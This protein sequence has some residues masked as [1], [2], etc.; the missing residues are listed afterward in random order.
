MCME[1][2]FFGRPIVSQGGN[3]IH[4]R[5]VVALA[6][7]CIS[8]PAI[9][10]AGER[11][12]GTLHEASVLVATREADV[13]EHPQPISSHRDDD[14][15]L[16]PISQIAEHTPELADQTSA[17][18]TSAQD[19]A[20]KDDKF[21]GALA[22]ATQPR[23]LSA[24]PAKFNGIQ[25]GKSTKDDVLAGWK[26]PDKTKST[27]DGSVLI[28]KTKPFR[29]VEVQLTGKL[30]TAIKIELQGTLSPKRLARQ[31][32]LD[33]FDPV[34]V[35]DDQGAM[36]GQIYPKR[37]VL[38]LFAPSSDV[39]AATTTPR[40][41]AVT[42]VVIQPLDADA[43]ALRA[44]TR[45]HGPYERNIEDL[46]TALALNPDLA[47]AQWLL[48]EIY[49]ATG[50]ADLAMEAADEACAIDPK[51]AAY[52]LRRAQ[53]QS[54]LGRYDDATLGVRDVLDRESTPPIVKA[55]A[56]HE[57]AILAT[58]GDAEI[59]SKA[60]PFDNRAIA[61][62]DSLATSKNIKERRAAKELLIEAHLAIAKQVAGNPFSNKLESVSQWVGRASGLAED[63]I[64]HDDGSVELRL[65]VAREALAALASLKPTKDPGPWIK[66]AEQ[67]ST[68]L[69]QQCDDELWRRRIQWELGQAYFQAVG[70]EHLRLQ[71]ESALRYGQLA[72]EN[73]AEG[74]ANRQSTYES[75]Q[76]VGKLY[77]HIGVVHAV[78]KKDHKTAA[79]W[80]DKALPL[81]TT[82]RPTSD[83]LAPQHDGE[84]LVSMAV[85]YWQIGEKDHAID[86]TLNGIELAEEAVVDGLLPE[87]SLAVPYGNLSAMYQQLGS[88]EDAAKYASLA[89]N[90]GGTPSPTAA[91][92]KRS[93]TTRRTPT[94]TAGQKRMLPPTVAQ[95]PSTSRWTPSPA[96][97]TAMRPS[98]TN[99][100]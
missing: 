84:E 77:F 46:E 81:L 66:E 11:G 63:M 21:G 92:N 33:K 54:A 13:D 12:A 38:F 85:S 94:M 59:S 39:I 87:K 68:A 15:T 1:V 7:L 6:G 73:L 55:Q 93:S 75:E 18:V 42:H 72:I 45:L 61:L 70:I 20:E 69:T 64:A 9:G 41:A 74:A 16:E 30:V 17:E 34:A 24:Q 51:N 99:M 86:L 8:T 47:H 97:R 56:L 88:A 43:F 35:T 60:I 49:L 28:Y 26:E 14:G 65:L 80:Y 23:K 100:R 79:E 27:K 58:L 62:A 96:P 2:N 32:S 89:K 37:G 90:A 91:P 57:M 10:L 82:P 78:E 40:R 76:L 83:L 48:A 19:D 50:Q 95:R 71:P 3:S 22:E 36:L 53:A 5:V 67:A 29:S 52:Q 31:L 25:P 4:R 98:T 44:E